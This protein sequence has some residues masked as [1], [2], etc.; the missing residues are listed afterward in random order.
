MK[1]FFEDSVYLIK[2]ESEMLSKDLLETSLYFTSDLDRFYISKFL[3][4]LIKSKSLVFL[5]Y[6]KKYTTI[7]TINI[8]K[9]SYLSNCFFVKDF[10]I[11]SS[12]PVIY[13]L[14]GINQQNYN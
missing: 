1:Y 9:N 13:H 7:S 14:N 3:M 5:F 12:K 11:S 8:N 4:K 6:T 2:I 10:D